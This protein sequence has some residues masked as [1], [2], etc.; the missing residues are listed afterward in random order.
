MRFTGLAS[1]LSM[2]FGVSLGGIAHGGDCGCTTS[3]RCGLARRP[4]ASST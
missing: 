3:A 2:V 1:V 4:A